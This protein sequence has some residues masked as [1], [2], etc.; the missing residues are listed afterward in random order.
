MDAAQNPMSEA[1]RLRL[2]KAEPGEMAWDA[3]QSGQAQLRLFPVAAILLCLGDTAAYVAAMF[4]VSHWHAFAADAQTL[5]NLLLLAAGCLVVCNAAA[6]LYPGYRLYAHELM[7]R[8]ALVMMKV[9]A[10]IFATMLILRMDAAAALGSFFVMAIILQAIAGVGLRHLAHRLGLWGDRVVILG[11]PTTTEHLSE[12]FERNWGLGLRPLSTDARRDQAIDAILSL[13][14]PESARIALVSGD[15]AHDLDTLIRLRS[16]YHEVILLADTPEMTCSGLRPSDIGGAVGITLN[17]VAS[18]WALPRRVLDVAVASLALLC[19]VPILVLACA[20]IWLIDPGPVIYRQER[21][22][23]DG[24]KVKVLKL[25][26]MYRDSEYRL[27]V[28]LR[29]CPDACA[30]W[31]AHFKLRDDPRIL[32]VVGKLLRASSCDELPQL[33][34]VLSGHMSIVGPRPFPVYHLSAMNAE[35]RAKRHSIT[36]GITGLLQVS[37]RS[38]ADLPLQ[39]RIDDFYINNRSFWLD[40]DIL[41]KTVLAVLRRSGT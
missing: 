37:L 17:G 21:E 41:A 31:K 18:S 36:P 10:L 30:E 27:S 32:P 3:P 16:R 26:T 15:A 28:L 6:G 33:F 1:P 7:R 13:D 2:L 25:R 39:Q 4:V 9:G 23:L 19:C 24:R 29:D 40:A 8:R 35:F 38:E 12:Y 11:P 34:N 14:R 5:R 22:G 20:A